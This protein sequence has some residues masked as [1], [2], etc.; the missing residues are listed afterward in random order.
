MASPYYLPPGDKRARGAGSIFWLLILAALALC[1]SVLAE[2]GSLDP[3]F[4]GDGRV[5]TDLGSPNEDAVGVAV[6]PDGKIIVVGVNPGAVGGDVVLARYTTS[7]MLDAT[8]DGDGIRAF[9]GLR[10]ADVAVQTDGKIV[11]AGSAN[12][13]DFDDDLALA[14]FNA[15]G[16][17]DTSFGN[18]G[19]A[20]DDG[21]FNGND[22]GH[23]IGLQADGKIVVVGWTDQGSE[24]GD[25]VIGRFNGD[26]TPDTSFGGGD[27]RAVLS[28]G[29]HFSASAVAIQPNGKIVVGGVVGWQFGLVRLQSGGPLDDSFSGDGKVRTDLGANGRARDV[30]VQ[31]DGKIVVAGSAAGDFAL[32]RYTRRGRLDATFSHDGKKRT[33]FNGGYDE[34]RGVVLESNGRIVVA[35]SSAPPGHAFDANFGLARYRASGE[36]D[37]T[38][39]RNGKQRTRFGSNHQDHANDVALQA[40]GRI[41]VAGR[42]TTVIDAYD[43][44]LAR[45]LAQ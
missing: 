35:G 39:S 23:G 36:L 26:G 28:L 10:P 21:S 43:L 7:G 3:T 2:P 1:P 44:G 25:G 17:F 32:A 8:F 12:S 24:G 31:S 16:T 33:D 5:T 19:I 34:A 11:V 45:Y 38:F 42:I 27:G 14:R 41:V 6:Q 18:G 37:L 15:D 22:K 9:A 13:A 20:A 29:P 30:A 40:D 4:D